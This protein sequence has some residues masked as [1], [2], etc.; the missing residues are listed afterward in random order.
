MVCYEKT[1]AAEARR[2]RKKGTATTA[3]FI[4]DENTVGRI[5]TFLSVDITQVPDVGVRTPYSLAVVETLPIHYDSLA[6]MSYSK[7][8]E[9][10]VEYIPTGS[11]QADLLSLAS[12]SNSTNLPKNI[13]DRM[14]PDI[15]DRVYLIRSKTGLTPEASSR[16]RY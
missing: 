8:S 9:S 10:K 5:M 7:I 3:N 12:Y 6:R 15:Q 16:F 2:T 4:L 1:M 14:P 11:I 13:R